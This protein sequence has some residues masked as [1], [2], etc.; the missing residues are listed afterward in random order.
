MP[1]NT[2]HTSVSELF[3]VCSIQS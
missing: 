3:V 1:V 2:N